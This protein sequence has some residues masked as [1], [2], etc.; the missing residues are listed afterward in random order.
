VLVGG[1]HDARPLEGIEAGLLDLEA[2][3]IAW[4]GGETEQTLAVAFGVA[5][6]VGALTGDPA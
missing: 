4:H 1:D 3:G 5:D 6:F 2:V